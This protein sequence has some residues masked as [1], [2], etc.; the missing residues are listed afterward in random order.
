M[1][2]QGG[3]VNGTQIGEC[4]EQYRDSIGV[5][6]NDLGGLVTTVNDSFHSNNT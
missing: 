6:I 2:W 3:V 4:K 1:D 5:S